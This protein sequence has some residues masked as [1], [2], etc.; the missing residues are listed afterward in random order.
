V[1]SSVI[2]VGSGGL[3]D[4]LYFLARKMRV[5]AVDARHRRS[6]EVK[7][8]SRFLHNKTIKRIVDEYVSFIEF[9]HL[10]DPNH[11]KFL[12]MWGCPPQNLGHIHFHGG[13]LSL[14]PG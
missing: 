12:M 1:N 4:S 6:E 3:G 2:D 8:M 9:T 5:L 13:P 11:I 10:I 14:N 7:K